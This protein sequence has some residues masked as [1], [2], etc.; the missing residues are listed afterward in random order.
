MIPSRLLTAGRP[1]AGL[2]AGIAIAAALPPF[3]WWPLAIAGCGLLVGALDGQ[4]R[5]VR[6]RV[7]LAAGLGWIVPGFWW[8]TEFSAPGF[9][10]ASLLVA[11]MVAVAGAVV[12]PGRWSSVAFPAA[13]VALE[14]IRGAWP[15]G[16]VPV[17]T[18]AHTQV[19]GPI[20]Q[21]ARLGGALAV[22]AVVAAAGVALALAVR[23]RW[24][25]A[26]AAGALVTAATVAGLL[27]AP[28]PPGDTLTIAL[29]QGGG[30]RGTRAVDS[31]AQAVFDA[32]L[33][34]SSAVP[35]G[36]D[37]VLWPE[38]VVDVEGAFASTDEADDLATLARRLGA[39]L[40]AGIV[41]DEG[42]TRFRNYA[43]AWS[44]GGD[45]GPE[46]TK[47]QRVPF[48]EWIPFRSLVERLADI[49]AVPR[50][51]TVGKGPGL[52][53]T[54]A[55]RL[56]V[57]LSY[58]V[59]FARR[60]RDAVTA[61]GEVLLVPTN[62]SSYTTTQMPALELGA[63]RL[64]A[65]ETG[66]WVL[67]AAPTGFSALIDPDGEVH[68]ATNL[69]RRE[70]VTAEVDLRTGRTPYTRLGDGPFVVLAA[71]VLAA[72]WAAARR[73]RSLSGPLSRRRHLS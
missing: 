13:I 31:S 34:A 65:V 32:H 7:A 52:L 43:K 37:L 72:S 3:G 59:F 20:G 55:G 18:L 2:A 35:E 47:N 68:L 25:A 11:G 26:A 61:G 27:V 46:Y 58:E 33:S 24:V 21:V 57:V 62:A 69:G 9:A 30:Q 49:S 51:A 67:Q 23:R 16:G 36:V 5:R 6:L 12:P 54:E 17:S 10:L 19:G 39:T 29:V 4:P 53:D 60:A 45:P 42:S 71:V 8:M 50:D 15:F 48:G 56:G 44:P 41:E 64:R 28:P 70:V 38:D 1:A 40:V 22:S 63:A 73:D 14:A 66:R